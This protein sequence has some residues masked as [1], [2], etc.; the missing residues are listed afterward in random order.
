MAA[1][2]FQYR[3]MNL[4]RPH[5]TNGW[6]QKF[7]INVC[8]RQSAEWGRKMGI[9][10]KAIAF[11]YGIGIGLADLYFTWAWLLSGHGVGDFLRGLFTYAI[12]GWAVTALQS[13][14]WPLYAAGV[15]G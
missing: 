14:V 15:L 2:L 5:M 10:F 13:F 11:F 9:Y 7:L 1:G 8:A 4:I 12:Y 3:P 6:M